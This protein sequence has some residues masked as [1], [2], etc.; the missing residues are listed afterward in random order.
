MP[1]SQTAISSLGLAAQ[2]RQ[3]KADVIVEIAFGLRDPEI[4]ARASRPT[5]SLVLVLPLLPV[6]AMTLS[7]SDLR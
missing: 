2:H 7:G 3:R 6:M 5:K 1:I 4:R